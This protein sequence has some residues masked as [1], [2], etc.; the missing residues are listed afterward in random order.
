MV[1]DR[2]ALNSFLLATYGIRGKHWLH[3]EKNE[4]KKNIADFHDL[5]LFMAKRH[6]LSEKI[7]SVRHAPGPLPLNAKRLQP[8]PKDL[9]S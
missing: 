5:E 8:R 1:T 6:G 7:F 2:Q 4:K 9:E 3:V